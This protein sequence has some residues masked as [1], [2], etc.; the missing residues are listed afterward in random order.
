MKKTTNYETKTTKIPTT[1]SL[2]FNKFLNQIYLITQQIEDIGETFNKKLIKSSS[3][4]GG[5]NQLSTVKSRKLTT[6]NKM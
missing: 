2:I 1:K 3:T 4:V 6:L 5:K